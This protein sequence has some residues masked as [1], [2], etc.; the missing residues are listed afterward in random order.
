MKRLKSIVLVACAVIIGIAMLPLQSASAISSSAL[1]IVP[2]K[3]YT[4]ESGKSVKDTLLIRN[5]DEKETLSLTLRV[6]DFTYN[7]DGGTPKLMLAEDAP[8]TTW[9][10]KPFIKL[11]KTVSIEPKK[12]ASVDMN[13]A[14]PAGH[15]AG[16]YYSA[17]VYSAGTPEE[18]NVGVSASGV[19]LA[20]INVPGEVKEDLKLEKF[21]AYFPKNSKKEAGFT[22][23]ATE[24]PKHIGYTLKNN[25]NVTE[26]PV[27]TI[28]VKPLFGKDKTISNI[29]P[30]QS[31]ALIGQSRTYT[32]CVTPKLQEVSLGGSTTKTTECTDSGLWPGFYRLSLDMFYG[33]N[34][35]K[36]QDLQGS[37]WFIYM[38]VWAI[39]VLI[40]LLLVIGFFGYRAYNSVR[41]K[42]GKGKKSSRKK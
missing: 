13:V 3:N 23:F 40:L 18:G 9:S 20:F 16:S 11:P 32:A 10:A 31:L 38:P 26:A 6:V 22:F 19:T 39:I 25:G 42:F 5:L 2:K 24:D 21:G 15:G 36:T 14:I 12:S 37:S 27:G 4:I 7:N 29:N 17:I 8:Q 30:N 34:G 1:S 35:N 33:Q 28:T 41:G